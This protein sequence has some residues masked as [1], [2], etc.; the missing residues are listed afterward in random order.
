MESGENARGELETPV[1][2]CRLLFSGLAL[3]YGCH[4]CIF[5]GQKSLLPSYSLLFLNFLSCPAINLNWVG[6]V[7]VCAN[8][9]GISHPQGG[10]TCVEKLHMGIYIFQIKQ[11]V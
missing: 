7:C 5:N 4:I 8:A 9:R 3:F 1:A 6:S 2:A 10:I 11:L